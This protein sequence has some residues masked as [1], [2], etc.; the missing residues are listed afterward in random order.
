MIVDMEHHASTA[1]MLYKGKSESGK[2]VERYWD[3]DGKM[4][5]RTYEDAGRVERRLQ[6]MDEAGIDVASLTPNPVSTLDQCRKWNDFCASV[7]MA[8]PKRFVGFAGI[9]PLGGDPAMRE[10]ERAVK[11]LGLKGVHI[12]TQI[13]GRPLDSRELWPF[14]EK[15]SELG[16]PVDVHVT[17]EPA[18]FDGLHAPYA[19]YYVMA[20]ELDMCA[21]TMRVC[22]GGVLEDFPDLVMIMNHFGGGISAVMERLDAYMNYVGP[23]CPSLYRDR[24]LISKPWRHYFDRLYF[25]MAGREVGMAAVK[26]AL[27]NISPKKL[28]F[29]TDW[30]FNFDHEPQEVRRF[31]A[32]IR[33]LDIPREDIEDM[34]GGNAAR[35]LGL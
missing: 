20:R 25:N 10:L 1:D 4:K 33:E 32:D 2:V 34:L 21:A 30:P 22:L 19:L 7:V 9:P 3:T 28:M 12:W 23:G 5:I 29:G 16:I 13:G 8:H 11:G 27:T 31:A 18:G 6:F 26:A 24:P 15:V 14:Y 35:L 17:L